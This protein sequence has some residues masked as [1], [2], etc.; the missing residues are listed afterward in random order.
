MSSS[1][2]CLARLFNHCFYCIFFFCLVAIRAI[3]DVHDVYEIMSGASVLP[4]SHK[5]PKDSKFAT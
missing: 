5:V 3:V 2:V 4:N 1:L